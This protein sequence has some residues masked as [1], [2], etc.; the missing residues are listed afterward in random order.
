M[1]SLLYF[2]VG[3]HDLDGDD[4]LDFSA[5]YSETCQFDAIDDVVEERCWASIS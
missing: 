3:D 2:L 4:S 1:M 5:R